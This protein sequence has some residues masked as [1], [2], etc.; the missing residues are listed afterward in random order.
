LPEV[1]E[2][3]VATSGTVWYLYFVLN[4]R[5]PQSPAEFPIPAGF[6]DP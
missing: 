4:R 2:E 1:F 5:D 6:V 3:G